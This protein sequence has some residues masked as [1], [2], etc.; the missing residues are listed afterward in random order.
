MKKLVSIVQIIFVMLLLVQ[1]IYAKNDVSILP[2]NLEIFYSSTS[3]NNLVEYAYNPKTN[4]AIYVFNDHKY[5]ESYLIDRTSNS[6]VVSEYGVK[7]GESSYSMNKNA[8]STKREAGSPKTD[9]EVNTFSTRAAATTTYLGRIYYNINGETPGSRYVTFYSGELL[10]RTNYQYQ[11]NTTKGTLASIA[12]KLVLGISFLTLPIASIMIVNLC[13]QIGIGIVS[14]NV[15]A[16]LNETVNADRTVYYLYGTS[17][18]GISKTLTGY[19]YYVSLKRYGLIDLIN[20]Y[21]EGFTAYD[22]R[23]QSAS[24]GNRI[25]PEYFVD[26]YWNINRWAY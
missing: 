3:G 13:A 7:A 6:I 22:Y 24:L 10:D 5:V 8:T 20:T 12:S 9:L 19:S 11:L 23:R 18:F 16:S 14:N 21:T 1:P 25:F 2:N 17:N 26:S 15:T 4:D